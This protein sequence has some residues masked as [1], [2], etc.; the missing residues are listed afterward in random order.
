MLNGLLLEK[1][2][3]SSVKIIG[4]TYVIIVQQDNTRFC[5]IGEGYYDEQERN[6]VMGLSL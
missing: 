5:V 1:R 4:K 6:K 3:E 2:E